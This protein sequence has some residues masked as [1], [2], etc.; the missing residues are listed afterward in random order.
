MNCLA[1][2]LVVFRTSLSDELIYRYDGMIKSVEETSAWMGVTRVDPT[3]FDS[4]KREAILIEPRDSNRQYRTLA[5]RCKTNW[6]SKIS[7]SAN[8]PNSFISQYATGYDI[9]AS[10]FTK[11]LQWRRLQTTKR[12]DEL[13]VATV[14]EPVSEKLA[15]YFDD[16]HYRQGCTSFLQKFQKYFGFTYTLT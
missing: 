2:K 5:M 4:E 8:F 9:F 12:D 1:L 3:K 6:I 11:T 13:W 7:K 16:K 14:Q 15:F 10:I